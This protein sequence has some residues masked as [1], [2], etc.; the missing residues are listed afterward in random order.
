MGYAKTEAAPLKN[1]ISHCYE[2]KKADV[3]LPHIL[4]CTNVNVATNRKLPERR[5]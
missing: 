2:N 4:P 5:K 1:S 3:I